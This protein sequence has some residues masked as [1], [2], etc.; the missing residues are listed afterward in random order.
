M[1]L[2]LFITLSIHA[3]VHVRYQSPSDVY[4][5]DIMRHIQA[6]EV[7]PLTLA[8][9]NKH[10]LLDEDVTYVFGGEEGPSYDPESKQILIPYAFFDEVLERFES[11]GKP[12][13]DRALAA[14]DAGLLHTLYHEFAHALIDVLQIPVLGKE[15]DA[16]DGFADWVLISWHDDHLQTL[17]DAAHLFYLES[18]DYE[19]YSDD[20]FQDEHSLDR[21]RYFQTL[22]H[23]IGAQNTETS[24]YKKVKSIAGFTIERTELCQE[25]YDK[26]SSDWQYLL[27]E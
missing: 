23:L 19:T 13:S 1:I 26:L 25:E 12:W 24:V 14:S 5:Q 16:A 3:E 2:G 8:T 18:L 4:E 6:S 9:L 7:V 27:F 20:L 11:A 10:L 21:Q 17:L 22:C 15:E